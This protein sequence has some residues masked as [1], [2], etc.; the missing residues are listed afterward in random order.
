MAFLVVMA[1]LLLGA[2]TASARE[3]GLRSSLSASGPVIEQLAEPMGV[4]GDIYGWSVASSRNG[5]VVAV[6][7]HGRGGT[8][9]VFMWFKGS[10]PNWSDAVV[11]E[12][13]GPVVGGHFGWSVAVTPDAEYLV[14][15]DPI[16][17]NVYVYHVTYSQGWGSALVPL[18]VPSPSSDASDHF[19]TSVD[20]SDNAD[21][22]VVG[23][24]AQTPSVSMGNAYIY[25]ITW[26]TTGATY[27]LTTTL[28]S[29][30]PASYG[31][32]VAL[33]G[34]SKTLV[35]SAL[36]KNIPGYIGVAYVYQNNATSSW[37]SSV[38][39]AA[40][41]SHGRPMQ[42]FGSGLAISADGSAIVVGGTGS[43]SPQVAP[44]VGYWQRPL[45]GSWTGENVPATYAFPPQTTN[46]YFGCRVGLSEGGDVLIVGSYGTT[47]QNG[48]AY[49]YTLSGGS[50]ALDNSYV[51]AG[52]MPGDSFGGYVAMSGDGLSC[53]ISA[54]T[55]NGTMGTVYLC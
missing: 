7:A 29:P 1:L 55:A 21:I 22:I 32:N 39:E 16:N 38:A 40:S 47:S 45:G 31:F 5:T 37:P 13:Q 46:A 27:G 53:F 18:V 41:L 43:I 36:N 52:G 24:P 9:S 50:W 17:R 42:N 11:Y 10:Q 28:A 8:G 48:I 20:I 12:I 51:A 35:V 4:A 25:T 6:G 30:G 49:H 44:F 54:P 26:G 23:A 19:G 2:T 15:G 3:S 34:D 33:S 14:V